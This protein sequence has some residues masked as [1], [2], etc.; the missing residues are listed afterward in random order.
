MVLARHF[1]RR[2]VPATGRRGGPGLR[3]L[4]VALAALGAIG[5]V[6]GAAR[7]ASST[8]AAPAATATA[9]I[10]V[11][12]KS[13]TIST[14][15]LAYRSC[16]GGYSSDVSLGFPN[17]HCTTGSVVVTNGAAPSTV[18]VSGA[19]AAPSDGGRDWAL[20]GG[21]GA[22][23]CNVATPGVDQFSEQDAATPLGLKGTCDPHFGTS[24]CGSANPRQAETE[25]LELY[26]P[27][28]STDMSQTFTTQITWTAS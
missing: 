1:N 23:G 5:G 11:V 4:C 19:N 20:C 2:P 8:T 15:Q 3:A 21:L 18:L 27:K 13:V 12:F 14:T 26:G 22:P 28:S 24:P 6:S 9:T 16:S 17:G 25:S 10:S 7:A